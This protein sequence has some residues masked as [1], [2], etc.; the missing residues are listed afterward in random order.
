MIKRILFVAP[1]IAL[2]MAICGMGIV[3][4]DPARAVDTIETTASKSEPAFA[5]AKALVDA[6]KYNEALTALQSLD[7][8]SPD[9]PDV[10]NLI[11]FSLRKTGYVDGALDYYSRA[12]ALKP[13]HLG[14]NEY[15]GE[16]Y[17]EL[18]QPAKAEQRLEVLRRACTDCEE[19]RDLQA[20]I[21]QTAKA[22]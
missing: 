20:K 11:G 16:L 12:L 19:F 4:S 10:L 14:T 15:L 13:D 1:R 6:G 22:D 9:N 17:L 7:A 5:E 2:L 8:Q 18:R 21:E 3:A